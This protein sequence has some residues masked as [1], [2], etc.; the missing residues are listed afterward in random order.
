VA[1]PVL[2]DEKLILL[3]VPLLIELTVIPA[4]VEDSAGILTVG[5][6]KVIEHDGVGVGVGVGVGSGA[7]HE[8]G[9][10]AFWVPHLEHVP[11]PIPTSLSLQSP[12]LAAAQS[13]PLGVIEPTQH[14]P[15]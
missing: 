3:I 5:L 15:L 9:I 7:L 6:L 12:H 11:T 2:D 4:V 13:H 1:I 8:A 14:V 10:Q